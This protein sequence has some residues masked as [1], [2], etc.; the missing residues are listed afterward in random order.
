MDHS[1]HPRLEPAELNSTNLEGAIVYDRENTVVGAISHL[2]GVGPNTQ[3]IVD[4]GGFLGIGTKPVALSLAQ[5]DVMRDEART[6]H[7]VTQLTRDA[8]ENLPEH[9]H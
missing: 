1:L 8:V 3:A 7:A 6:V 2:H 5:L 9:R 4:V